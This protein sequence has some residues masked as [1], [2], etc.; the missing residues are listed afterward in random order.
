[1][2]RKQITRNTYASFDFEGCGKAIIKVKIDKEKLAKLLEKND[3]D[4]WAEVVSLAEN[5]GFTL[6]KNP[7]PKEQMDKM[8]A[9]VA[10][11]GTFNLAQAAKILDNYRKGAK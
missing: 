8:R 1:M 11:G 6:P 2:S 4:L 7:P 9:A 3:G 10:H 5:K